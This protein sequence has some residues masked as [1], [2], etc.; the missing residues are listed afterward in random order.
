MD[1]KCK[2]CSS[3]DKIKAILFSL[4]IVVI[5]IVYIVILIR[6]KMRSLSS[7]SAVQLKL[8]TDFIQFMSLL[9]ILPSL[10]FD[11][12]LDTIQIQGNMGNPSNLLAALDCFFGFILLDIN[13]FF[14]KIILTT[15]LTIL[16]P[17]LIYFFWRSFGYI[18]NM[19]KNTI[20][21]GMLVW[22]L[23]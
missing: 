18:R 14:K 15:F 10:L 12:L 17:I 2:S 8:F 19:N 13:V 16:I 23:L 20:N 9:S 21:F 1:G 3:D 5:L 22:K 7:A 11:S 4:A 6:K